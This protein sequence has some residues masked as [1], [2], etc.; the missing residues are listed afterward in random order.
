MEKI[1]LEDLLRYLYKETSPEKTAQVA[2]ALEN[3][4][5]LREKLSVMA[6][7][8]K[9]LDALT[10]SPRQETINNILQYAEKGIEELSH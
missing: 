1:T 10:A 6:S 4:F 2:A 3:D 8:S 7:A 9:R 5:S